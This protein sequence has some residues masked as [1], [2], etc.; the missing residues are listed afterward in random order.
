MLQKMR[1]D[2]VTAVGAPVQILDRTDGDGPLVEAPNLVRSKEG[3]YFLFYSSGCTRDSSYVSRPH[4][5]T[6][7][8]RSPL[9]DERQDIKYATAEHVAGPYTRAGR[10]LL[11]TG[12]W[13][14]EAPG[15]PSVM[16]NADDW[17]Y[18]MAFHARMQTAEGGV[19]AMW[20]SKLSLE[21]R[22][23]RLVNEVELNRIEMRGR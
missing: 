19:R 18:L 2:G 1:K 16:R 14:L 4:T 3:I 13:S 12:D 5:P 21:G 23:A 11:R 15:S 7:T 6:Q 17:A 22:H 8:Q 10:P 9:T 20:W